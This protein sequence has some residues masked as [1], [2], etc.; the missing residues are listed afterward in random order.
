MMIHF[1]TTNSTYLL[2]Y[3][4]PVLGAANSSR[5]VLCVVELCRLLV[6]RVWRLSFHPFSYQ[7]VEQWGEDDA[8]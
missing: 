6:S 7:C 5:F 8:E 4:A 1:F 2:E 3:L